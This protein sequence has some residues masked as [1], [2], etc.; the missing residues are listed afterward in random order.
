MPSSVS[1]K[2]ALQALS[3]CVVAGEF[4]LVIAQGAPELLRRLG[5]GGGHHLGLVHRPCLGRRAEDASVLR[6][7]PAVGQRL[8]GHWQ[9]FE[10]LGVAYLFSLG[11][12]F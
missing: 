1:V 6:R 3:G 10:L 2:L 9:R 11:T 5:L 8:S 7:D 4:V 12:G